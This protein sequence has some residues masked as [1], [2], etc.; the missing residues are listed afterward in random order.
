MEQRPAGR[1]DT[2]AVVQAAATPVNSAAVLSTPHTCT[3]L[4]QCRQARCWAPGQSRV[5]WHPRLQKCLAV[6]LTHRCPQG[7][8]HR[9]PCSACVPSQSVDHRGPI[10]VLL[11]CPDLS[12]SP[13]LSGMPSTECLV[14]ICLA[15]S[16]V[17]QQP[18]CNGF[19]VQ[20]LGRCS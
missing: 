1:A 11:R 16:G 3:T 4:N 7:L 2:A 5:P 17:R 9:Q 14:R 13:P 10:N 8:H 19:S 20:Q 15:C 6:S 18:S 12:S